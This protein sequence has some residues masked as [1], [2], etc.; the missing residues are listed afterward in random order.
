MS[1]ELSDLVVVITGASSGIGRATALEFASLGSTVVLASRDAE[2]LEEI[3]ADCETVGG[4]ALAVATDV[5]IE[6]QVRDLARRAVSTFG[7]IDVWVNNASVALFARFDVAPPDVYRRVIETNL[8]GYIHGARAALREFRGAGRGWLINVDSVVGGAP[9]PF[10][11]AYVASKYAVRG[12]SSCLRM[13]LQLDGLRDIHV[14]TVLPASVDTPLFQH[15]ANYTGRAI[16]ALRP[17]IKA[18]A[19]AAA[20]VGLIDS[21]REEVIVGRAGKAMAAQAKL[22]PAT[23]EKA[24]ARFY[25]RNHF[26]D[27]PARSTEGNVF[28]STGPKD[29]TGGW[30][31][32]VTRKSSVRW[33]A[34]L[35]GAA[36]AAGV[37]VF[38]MRRD[39]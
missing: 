5:T 29:T 32:P 21:P 9:Q 13:E 7:R 17:T 33:A 30:S 16:K 14:S 6:E 36:V 1:H 25:E 34:G 11:S 27:A 12:W 8:F 39:R 3:A 20:I 38:L 18:E 19:V 31:R 22:A 24:F 35:A 4:R 2:T 10:T 23:Y 15:A 37:S 26:A 28:E